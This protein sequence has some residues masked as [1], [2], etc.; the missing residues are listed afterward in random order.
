MP[1]CKNNPMTIWYELTTPTTETLTLGEFPS[2][3]VHTEL[4]VTGDFPP[5][6][7]GTVKV[8]N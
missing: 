7:T 3:P 8:G 4:A 1:S 5:D 6:V 2:Y